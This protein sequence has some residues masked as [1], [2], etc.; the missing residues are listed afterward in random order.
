MCECVSVCE[1]VDVFVCVH[2][3]RL[4]HLHGVINMIINMINAVCLNTRT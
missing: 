1:C 3:C 2:V 4:D